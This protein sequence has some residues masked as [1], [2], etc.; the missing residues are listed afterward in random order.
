RR[1]A[2]GGARAGWAV[3][4]WIGAVVVLRLTGSR[5]APAVLFAW[6]LYLLVT[7]VLPEAYRR[8]VEKGAN[9]FAVAVMAYILTKSWMPLGIG[10]GLRRNLL[11]VGGMIGG[12]LFLVYLFQRAYPA[13]L[14]WCL[15][16]KTVFLLMP[17]AL[18]LFGAV[19]WL[20]F[21][22]TWGWVP[23]L[24]VRAGLEEKTVRLSRPWVWARHKFPGLGKEFMPDLDEGSFLLMPSTMPHASIGEAMDVLGKEDLALTALPEVETAVGKVGRVESALD[25]APVSMVETVI[26]YRPEY[27][28]DAAGNPPTFRH[29]AGGSSLFRDPEGRPVP[30]PDGAPYFVRGE[31]LR[32]DGKLVPDPNGFPFR[33]WRPPLESA[34]NPGRE[35]WPG[36]R[37]PDDIWEEILRATEL[38][39][40]TSAP[41]LQP[42]AAR[43]VMLQSGMRA[44]MGVKLFGKGR[45]SLED[46]E[47]AG[48]EIE[49]ILRQVPSVKAQAVTA[50]RIVGKPYLEI[51][52]DRRAIARYNASVLDVQTVIQTAVGGMAVT[53]TVEGRERYEVRV[54]YLREIR[55]TIEGLERV[56]VPTMGGA[57][58]PL[59]ELIV[60]RGIRYRRGPME[61][62]SEDGALVS[63]VLFD[64]RPG[65]AEVD[66]VRD[67]G[68]AIE[69]RLASGELKLPQGM[70]YRFAGSY[71]N[72]VR[73]EKRLLLILPLALFLI[74]LILYFQFRSVPTTLLVFTGI[75]VAWA[76]GFVMVWLYGESWFCNVSVFGRNVRELFQMHPINLSVAIWVG[77]IALFGIATD[78]G[79]IVATYL[80]QS[81]AER[82]PSTAAEVREATSA[83]A[84]RRI[85]PCLM[86]A[87]TTI[88]ALLPV[89]TSTG[90]GADIMVPMAIPSFGGMVATLLTAFIVPVL[91]SAIEELRLRFRP[92]T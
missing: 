39:G 10:L 43:A 36:I 15:A 53:T 73:S 37:S 78:N 20:G 88:L 1:R 65:R 80:R 59:K 4:L 29:E 13:M 68:R 21:E 42:I 5:L 64:K 33:L 72:Q 22:R 27:L 3:L 87:T 47:R 32:R 81:F 25:P 83:A 84:E 77:F 11:F 61:I 66:V 30:A 62:K 12:L 50:E 74:F 8:A 90:R 44:P 51:E 63:Y 2:R 76:G 34:L 70:T 9:A 26:N 41:R 52:I 16:H 38:P 58:I 7:P 71:E 86:T 19:I 91:Y 46:L 48:I 89:L 45:V 23:R 75:F 35:A 28:S 14:R 69:E 57:Q 49:R 31:F 55:D 67:A 24:A 79:V 18:C 92:R 82:T 6:G 17:V 40:T 56:L 85:R 54:R 60:G